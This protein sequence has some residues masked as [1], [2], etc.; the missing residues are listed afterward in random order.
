MAPIDV[1]TKYDNQT[2]VMVICFSGTIDG[3]AEIDIIVDDIVRS[4]DIVSEPRIWFVT[5]FTEM[6]SRPEDVSSSIIV[7][8]IHPKLGSLFSARTL[9]RVVVAGRNY[10]I[11]AFISL[12]GAVIGKKAHLCDTI[13]QALAYI[14]KQKQSLKNQ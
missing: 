6:I 9:G 1:K 10:Y 4:F 3:L 2:H 11:K 5:D 12:L 14:E 8:N 13:E 7:R